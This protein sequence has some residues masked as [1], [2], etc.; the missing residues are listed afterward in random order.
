MVA[1]KADTA[2]TKADT[3]STYFLYTT[4]SKRF[5]G[6]PLG[7]CQSSYKT[8]TQVADQFKHK[9][10]T[11]SN[12]LNTKRQPLRI[13][14]TQSGNRFKVTSAGLMKNGSRHGK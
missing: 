8:K 10:T 12:R 14:L 4:A 1:L 3:A 11:A 13:G 6:K 2:S 9:A 7:I 5:S